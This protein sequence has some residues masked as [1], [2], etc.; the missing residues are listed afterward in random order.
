MSMPVTIEEVV[1]ELKA[2]PAERVSEVYDFVV[3]LR[4]RSNRMLDISDEWTEEDMR[5]VARASLNYAE[6][7]LDEHPD[8]SR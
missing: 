3:F 5:D 2:L 1:R 7:S 8:G 6:N 4:T